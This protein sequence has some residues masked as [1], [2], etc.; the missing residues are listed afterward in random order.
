MKKSILIALLV[1]TSVINAYSQVK[2]IWT[3]DIPGSFLWQKVFTSGNFL[4]ANAEGLSKINAETGKTVWTLKQFSNI[5]VENVDELQGSSLISVKNNEV[6][7]L[8]DPFTGEIK[9]DSRAVGILE[10]NEKVVLYQSNSLFLA[11]KDA[12]K[13]PIILLVDINKGQVLW[14]MQEE[15]GGIISVNELSKTEL[16]LVTIFNNYK[17][18]LSNGA[19]I[20]KNA[21]SAE[22]EKVANMGGALGGLV[23]DFAT[24]AA[25]KSDIVVRYFENPTKTVFV[26][27]V[28][29]KENKPSPDGK[30]TVV[31]YKSS[32][33][34]Y[35]MSDGKRFWNTAIEMDG[36]ISQCAFYNDNFIIMPS[37]ELTTKVNM[38]D[39]KTG[40]G[41]WGKKG[42][43]TKVNGGVS[44]CFLANDKMMIVATKNGKN[45]LY[46][47]DVNT[48][49][50]L[51]KKPT[52]IGGEILQTFQTSK[53]ILY[54]T[55]NEINVIDPQT[56]LLA[57]EKSIYT[58]PSLCKEKED[59]LYVY[60]K[61]QG[62]IIAIDLM[63][64]AITNVSQ[65]SVYAD[66]KEEFTGI[67]LRTDGFVLT[68]SQNIAL[69][70][71]T[72]ATVYSKYFPAPKESGLMQALLYA[73]AAR[74]AYVGVRAAQVSNAF[75]DAARQTNNAS[76]QQVLGA[77]GNAYADYSKE[78]TGFALQSIKQAQARFKASSQGRD[79]VIVLTDT[80]HGN[81]LAVVNKLSGQVMGEV[82]LGRE[83][84]P[85]YTV[86]DVSGQIFM[87]NK[88]GNIVSYK[89][90]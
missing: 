26:L 66:G 79:F 76:G 20:W 47:I 88:K 83:K 19:V 41:K 42:K 67:E 75:N 85:K 69:I 28:E 81:V 37:D 63:T 39:L 35:N 57:F 16:L 10:L 18:N 58:N 70:S 51:F 43:G 48:G 25:E 62:K 73:Q 54:L 68:S 40:T 49:L 31:V 27:G 53:G 21:I 38:F 30:T 14:R 86:D 55:G 22:S 11:G 46:L 44:G 2:E 74:A 36:K 33:H 84:S 56:G 87:E 34:A 65:S 24:A 6:T 23:K 77:F 60:D 17:I 90:N 59:K 7:Y 89:L 71:S 9:F 52:K 50:P 13:L 80:D 4:I 1:F 61:S 5:A 78:A 45:S 15:F 64:C 8:I 82:N 72:G 29:K 3:K 12:A 32:Y